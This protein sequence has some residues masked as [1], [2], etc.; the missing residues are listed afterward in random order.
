MPK[1][2]SPNVF[3]F[4]FFA[5]LIVIEFL[6]TTSREVAINGLFWDKINHAFAF[7]VLFILANFAFK[8][9][10][11]WIIFW[12]IIFGLQ[13][14]IVQSF[15]PNREFS[16]LDIVADFIGI[17]IGFFATKIYEFWRKNGKSKIHTF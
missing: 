8:I 1:I 12:L 15:L 13:I 10:K 2:F 7:F 6:A 14:E 11:I 5:C 3:K 4:A 17:C 9:R 16:F